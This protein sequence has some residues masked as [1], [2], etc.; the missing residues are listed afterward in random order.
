MSDKFLTTAVCVAIVAY[1]SARVL[2]I[3]GVGG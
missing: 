1:D 3:L 2:C